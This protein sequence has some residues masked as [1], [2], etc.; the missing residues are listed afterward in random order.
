MQTNQPGSE[1]KEQATAPR[2]VAFCDVLSPYIVYVVPRSFEEFERLALEVT[3]H[4][5]RPDAVTP[6]LTGD[7]LE[8]ERRCH[9]KSLKADGVTVEFR[10]FERRVVQA[11]QQA[12]QA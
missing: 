7:G 1:P 9:S 12:V 2:A 4:N 11:E 10:W 8:W 6:L 3:V 5:W